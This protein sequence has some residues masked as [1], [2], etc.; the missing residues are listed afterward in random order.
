MLAIFIYSCYETS[1][2]FNVYLVTKMSRGTQPVASYDC[3]MP[4]IPQEP[5]VRY[6]MRGELVS[7]S[8]CRVQ[9][10]LLNPGN[11]EPTDPVTIGNNYY[12]TRLRLFRDRPRS[13]STNVASI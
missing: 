12:C 11:G 1:K 2:D 10:H 13:M 3:L 7:Q 4:Y 8:P 6:Y 9:I 5:G